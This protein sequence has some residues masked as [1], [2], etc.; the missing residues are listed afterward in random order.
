MGDEERN[1]IT[2]D[3]PIIEPGTVV[4]IQKTDEE[5]NGDLTMDG[6][7]KKVLEK[8]QEDYVEKI[9]EIMEMML[10]Q[11]CKKA[12]D[13]EEKFQEILDQKIKITDKVEWD[14]NL[15]TSCKE[16]GA[17]QVTS[18]GEGSEKPNVRESVKKT[19]ANKTKL[20]LFFGVLILIVILFLVLFLTGVFE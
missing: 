9:D 17:V 11:K 12:V 7:L 4:D 19:W 6:A 18:D 20:A 14:D 5:A 16:N 15:P 8:D 2:S 13:I 10:P 1:L 3:Q